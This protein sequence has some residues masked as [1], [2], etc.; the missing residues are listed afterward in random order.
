MEAQVAKKTLKISSEHD[1]TSIKLFKI[2]CILLFLIIFL[3]NFAAASFYITFTAEKYF[4]SNLKS[5]KLIFKFQNK[6][7]LLINTLLANVN[8]HLNNKPIITYPDSVY[9]QGG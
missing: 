5:C 8:R 4:M 2:I 6:S 7:P 3:S 1:T 9:Q